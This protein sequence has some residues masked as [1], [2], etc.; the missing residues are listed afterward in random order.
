[1]DTPLVYEEDEIKCS[2]ETDMAPDD[3]EF[4]VYDS[5]IQHCNET[6][7]PRDRVF[8]KNGRKVKYSRETDTF[9]DDDKFESHRPKIKYRRVTGTAHD[10][11]E[12]KT[13]EPK[14]KYVKET[15]TVPNNEEFEVY[16][17]SVGFQMKI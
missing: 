11:E 2:S 16:G 8:Q 10:N 15:N 14:V 12:F 7:M 1:M 17:R 4:V 6:S 5:K 3:E 9:R 13:Y